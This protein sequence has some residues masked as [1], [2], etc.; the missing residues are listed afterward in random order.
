MKIQI[1]F[2][3]TRKSLTLIFV[4]C[5]GTLFSLNAQTIHIPAN[6][7][8]IVF[9][10]V[11]Y[12]I[13]TVDSVVLNRHSIDFFEKAKSYFSEQ[14]GR[15]QS[16]IVVSFK[17]AS[18]TVNVNFIKR[19]DGMQGQMYFGVYCNKTFVRYFNKLKLNLTSTSKEPC[20]WDI[21]LPAL[22]GIHFSGLDIETGYSLLPLEH[23]KKKQ[24]IAIGNSIT[25]GTGQKDVASNATYPYILAEKMGWR[26]YNLAVGA[27]AITPLIA[28]QTTPVK[29]DAITVLWGYNDWNGNKNMTTLSADYQTLLTKLRAYHPKARIYCIIP[30]FTTNTTPQYHLPALYTS[31]DTLRNTER[32][33]VKQLIASGDKKMY[34]IEGSELTDASDLNDV[35]HLNIKGAASFANKLFEIINPIEKTDNRNSKNNK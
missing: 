23:E 31:I 26:M 25:H 21:V 12:P 4:F 15:T 1:S 6:D 3:E 2:F 10:G 34:L 13:K 11:L 22:S 32:R 35:V 24:Y 5:A 17:T 33:V 9:R 7:P 27:S 19:I 29:A 14:K 16:G 18:P 30:I 8:N 28:D 20:T